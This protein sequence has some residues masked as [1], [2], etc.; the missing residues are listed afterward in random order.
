ME[1]TLDVYERPYDPNRPVVCMDEQSRQLIGEERI[2]IPTKPGQVQ[3]YDPQYVRNGTV[4]NFIFFEPLGN[5]RRVSVRERRTQLDWAEEVARLLDEDYP[6][7][8]VV[9]LVMDNLN[10][11][12]VGSLYERYQAE[13][14]RA[15]AK[16][17]EIH[18]TPK[19]GS[20]LNAAESEFSVLS[21]QCLD[22]RIGNIETFRREVQTWQDAR[23][24][25]GNGMDWQ[26]TTANARIKLKKLYPQI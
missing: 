2:P 26:F 1:D 13:Q 15:Y 23:N 3:R 10:T 18:F 25:M 17:L 12:K 5:W 19:H 22:R 24:A 21:V 8:E 6:D 7:V 11:H 4:N 16:R 9:V 14:A 20:W